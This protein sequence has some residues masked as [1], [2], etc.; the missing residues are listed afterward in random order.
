M[1]CALQITHHKNHLSLRQALQSVRPSPAA[2]MLQ[3]MYVQEKLH[4]SSI[5]SSEAVALVAQ[6]FKIQAIACPHLQPHA[7]ELLSR[8][9]LNFSE[10]TTLLAQ[11]IAALQACSLLSRALRIPMHC[12]AEIFSLMHLGWLKTAR[13][14]DLSLVVIEIVERNG[15]LE[16][17][18]IFERVGNVFSELRQRGAKMAI[19]DVRL[20]E[21]EV[22][23]I[24]AF[25]PEFIKVENPRL[26]MEA[27]KIYAGK[28]I[29]ELIATESLAH[30]AILHG[31]DFLQG[32]WIDEQIKNYPHRVAD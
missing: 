11:D 31:A 29:T 2:P 16:N 8:R 24:Q 10:K 7:W 15:L 22:R 27:K 32:F 21:L 4:N 9:P 13:S 28:I 14:I 19:D 20:T 6:H 25:S 30:E 5:W 17:P 3:L 23:E 26:A 12:N 18:A 1:F